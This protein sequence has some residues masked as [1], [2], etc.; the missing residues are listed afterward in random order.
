MDKKK[1]KRERKVKKHKTTMKRKDFHFL[2]KEQDVR[3]E[4]LKKVKL[5]YKHFVF[6]FYFIL[7]KCCIKTVK[8]FFDLKC[9]TYNII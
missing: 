9:I 4:K 3:E 5:L 6:P 8:I 1:K 2:P 7:T